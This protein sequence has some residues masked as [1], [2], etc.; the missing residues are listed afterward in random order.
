MD[1]IANALGLTRPSGKELFN[2][3]ANGRT[4]DV[5]RLLAQKAP[6]EGKYGVRH[7]PPQKHNPPPGTRAL[8]V[9]KGAA[10][11]A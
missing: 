5:R 11:R 2:A 9:A 7:R 3:A 1:A 4:E 6:L 10:E 8:Y